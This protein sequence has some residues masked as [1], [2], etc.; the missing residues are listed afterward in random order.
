[1]K[2]FILLSL[3]TLASCRCNKPSK[4]EQIT[5]LK[6]QVDSLKLEIIENIDFI[7]SLKD[8]LQMSRREADYWGYK[9]DSLIHRLKN[10]TS[11]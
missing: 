2:K 9:Y 1:M 7:E 3:I 10:E 8:E 6:Y 4:N 5:T 11:K